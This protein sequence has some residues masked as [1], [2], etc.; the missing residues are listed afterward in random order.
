MGITKIK[1]ENFTVFKKA[2]INF[3]SG[4]N[5]LIGE[6]GTGKT[7]LLKLMNSL[8][9]SSESRMDDLNQYF[10]TKEQDSFIND[11]SV[12]LDI[13]MAISH[14]GVHNT[15]EIHYENGILEDNSHDISF[16][17]LQNDEKHILKMVDS[18]YSPVFIPAKDI[19]THSKSFMSLYNKFEMPFD[20]I[21]YDIISKSL[22]PNLKEVPE[23]G[24]SIL[25]TLENIMDGK[26]IVENEIFYIQ[27]TNGDKVEFSMEAEG[28]KKI[29]II[30]QLIMNESIISKSILFWDEP[31]ANLN[32]ALYKDVVEI[33]LALSR[34]GVQVFIATHDYIFAKYIEVLMKSND[35]IA[36][37]SLYKT[38]KN[39]VECEMGTTFRDLKQNAIIFSFDKLLDRVFALDIGD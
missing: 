23:I 8:L 28:V 39:S 37:H 36:F 17:F 29:A 14:S 31:E 6:N 7:H 15:I 12:A 34:N 3:A 5:V 4:M 11:N 22:L 10:L 9:R 26:V 24:K 16:T 19:L 20:R 13:Q 18:K 38:E 30:W 1:I 25:P 32:P 27:K 35:D 2:D 21:Y 33:L